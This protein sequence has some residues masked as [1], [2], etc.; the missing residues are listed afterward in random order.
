MLEKLKKKDLRI[1][2]NVNLTKEMKQKRL[3]TT[4]ESAIT[5]LNSQYLP[6]AFG[7]GLVNSSF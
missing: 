7:V 2:D 4:S 5:Y 3:W 1:S 6:L